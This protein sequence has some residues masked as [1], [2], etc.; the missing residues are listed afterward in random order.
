MSCRGR[1]N[2]THIGAILLCFSLCQLAITP[3]VMAQSFPAVTNFSDLETLVAKSW[4]NASLAMIMP[5]G[6]FHYENDL[7]VI[8]HEDSFAPEFLGALVP[9]TNSVVELFSVTVIE[10]NSSPRQRYYLNAA[11][12][13]VYTVSV[14][15]ASYPQ[16]FITN[17]FGAPPAYL[18]GTN[19]DQWYSDRDPARQTVHLALISVTNTTAYIAALTNKIGYVETGS[20]SIPFL[21][22][23]SNDIAF[24]G[25]EVLIE[26]T[27]QYFL[28][29]P[30][31]VAT[32]DVFVSTN[33]LATGGG[34]MWPS[35]INN[36]VD[37][38][39]GTMSGV[40]GPVFFAAD[41]AAIDSDGDGLPDC[42][43][44][45]IFGTDAFSSDTDADGLT[46]G[47][48]VM[49]WGCS[50][51]L[52][53]TD[54]SGM[55]DGEKIALGLSPLTSDSDGD[56]ATDINE[57]HLYF[58]DPHDPD[59]D[60]D[61]LTDGAEISAHTYAGCADSDGDGLTDKQEVDLGTNPLLV[62]TD[63][64][65]IDDKYEHD[66]TGWNPLDS[67]TVSG[68]D[69]GDGLSN[70]QEYQWYYSPKTSNTH[71]YVQR[72]IIVPPGIN[73]I[74][75]IAYSG[76]R[77]T[78][79]VAGDGNYPA[80]IWIRPLGSGTNTLP[81]RLHHNQVPGFYINGV[82]ASSMSSPIDI[83]A[84]RTNIEFKITSSSAAW[85]T[86]ILFRLTKTNDEQGLYCQARVYSP[87]IPSCTF[88]LSQG[89]S[90]NISSANYTNVSFGKTGTLFY[91]QADASD[92]PHAFL[93]PSDAVSGGNIPLFSQS[94]W[95]RFSVSGTGS[96]YYTNTM[97]ANDYQSAYG[98][99]GNT[100]KAYGIVLDPGKYAINAG[101]DMDQNAWLNDAEIQES[102]SC[103]VF[104][105]VFEPITCQPLTN[106]VVNPSG[107][108]VGGV[109][110]YEITVYPSIISDSEIIWSSTNSNISF[111]DG[112]T[113]RSVT[114]TATSQGFSS[115]K[116]DIAGYA[117]APPTIGVKALTNTVVPI[118]FIMI[119]DDS[120]NPPVSTNRVA[121]ML[122]RANGIYQQVAMSFVQQGSI[123]YLTNHP[124]WYNIA[125]Y[126]AFNSWPDFDDMVCYTNNTGGL[127]VY[128]VNDIEGA[129]GLADASSYKGIAVAADGSI[130]TLAHE[131]GHACG[132]ADIYIQK[133]GVSLAETNLAKSAWAPQDW[134]N[135]P[136]NMY[137]EPGTKQTLLIKRMLMYGVDGTDYGYSTFDIPLGKIYG[138]YRS[139]GTN[140][141]TGLV[142][143]GLDNSGY[144]MNRT[145]KSN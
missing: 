56:G 96:G 98:V 29:A 87:K 25:S 109:A 67:S 23:Y 55:S 39:S 103:T 108:E 70:L 134:N 53:S 69:D 35:K 4:T 10:T 139:S 100:R 82:D 51:L 111:P 41:N 97:N 120:G 123:T 62:D 30:T 94:D 84:V 130:N 133:N 50:P 57:V 1:K 28:H 106:P 93:Y 16:A 34:W 143:V 112:N 72:L 26:G 36:T 32:L 135:G 117:K 40:D 22:Y 48:E 71:D 75:T 15:L 61:G 81:Q 122:D 95:C 131:I 58:T 64:D 8:T 37:P 92:R 7:G 3:K 124:D 42:M 127:E 140:C 5:P 129:V 114:V 128:L 142:K 145:P 20:N 2:G 89:F 14:N 27:Y 9:S 118:S 104:R 19:L 21:N 99:P 44:T 101:F 68:D 138:V 38:L 86:N 43:E 88:S 83:P 110:R 132:L 46:D 80:R 54:G 76:S 17:T 74:R 52:A 102:C 63:G 105:T 33:L 136:G 12:S 91:C 77:D 90:N 107:I 60:N 6:S 47:D 125:Y 119:C 144:P 115:L 45:R 73:G 79:L 66:T 126:P 141:T 116:V 65:G 59:S 137:Y 11:G 78:M 13:T 85:G 49:K 113:G 24:V 18:T 31:N 121:Q